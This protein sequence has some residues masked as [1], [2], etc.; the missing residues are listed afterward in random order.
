MTILEAKSLSRAE[1]LAKFAE[2]IERK[3][4]DAKQVLGS[5]IMLRMGEKKE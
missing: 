4:S 5:E 1:L 3:D 2:A